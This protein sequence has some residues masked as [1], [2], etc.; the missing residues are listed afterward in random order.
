MLKGQQQI[1][2]LDKTVIN[3]PNKDASTTHS[4]FFQRFIIL[5]RPNMDPLRSKMFG[6][7]FCTQ[8]FTK[9]Q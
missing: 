1:R 9:G 8:I 2:D 5:F 6:S 4:I 3:W 7:I